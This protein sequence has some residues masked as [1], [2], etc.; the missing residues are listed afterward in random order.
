MTTNHFRQT[1]RISGVSLLLALVICS[2]LT[3]HATHAQSVNQTHQ[4]QASSQSS[5]SLKSCSSNTVNIV[6]KQLGPFFGAF[7]CH[8][9]T[10]TLGTPVIIVN[11][12]SL[13]KFVENITVGPF[14][15]V[16][17]HSTAMMQIDQTGTSHLLLYD[18]TIF[19]QAQLFVTVVS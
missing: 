4:S 7:S 17:A 12:T 6:F 1:M 14:I 16:T 10:I 5:T 13:N 15:H 2:F 9:M 18:D 3:F 11:P 8:K 19:P